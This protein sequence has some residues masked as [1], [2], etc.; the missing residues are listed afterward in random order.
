MKSIKLFALGIISAGLLLTSC[1]DD[2]DTNLGPVMTLSEI[3]TGTT[4]GAVTVEPGTPLVFAWRVSKGDANLEEFT[5]SNQGV[6]AVNPIPTSTGGNSFPY[7]IRNADNDTYVDTVAFSAGQ[8]EGVTTYT[9]AVT[10][11]NDLTETVTIEVTVENAGTPFTREI[12]GA[13]FHIEGT[14]QGAYDLI[15]EQARS[16]SEPDADKDMINTDM[17]GS[18]FTGSWQAGNSTTFVKD[19]SLDYDNATKE[20][21]IVAFNAG[22]ANG[23]VSN[24]TDGDIYIAKLRGIGEYFIIKIVT[25]DPTD[26][27]C[28]CGNTGKIT[29]DFKK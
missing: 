24:P 17:A 14:S 22:S 10:D 21:A 26:N 28:Q 1:E 18:T 11:G 4:S 23:S 29:F 13:F 19:N 20:E 25:V 3:G 15:T 5:I 7:S 6:N 16:A 27:S 8:N 2:E 9:F 12:T